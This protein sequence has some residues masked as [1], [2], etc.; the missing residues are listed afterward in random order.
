M[1]WRNTGKLAIAV[2]V[3]AGVDV[4]AHRPAPRPKSLPSLPAVDAT[5]VRG[6]RV[7]EG[8]TIVEFSRSGDLWRVTAPYQAR[9]DQ[10][11]VQGIVE[12]LARGVPMDV[13]VDALT[14]ENDDTYGLDNANLL[15]VDLLGEQGP[16]T[17]VYLGNDGPG[18]ASFVRRVDD[19]DVYRARLGG[20]HRYDRAAADWRDRQLVHVVAADVTSVVL[21]NVTLD[22]TGEGWRT[23]SGRADPDR[24]EDLVRGL[25]S[26]RIGEVLSTTPSGDPTATVSLVTSAGTSSIRFWR[27]V[28]GVVAAA[29]DGEAGRVDAA[30]LDVVSGAADAWRDQRLFPYRPD[31]VDAIV[32]YSGNRVTSAFVREKGAFVR[33]A[34]ENV[35][36][37]ARALT[38]ALTRL[39]QWRSE[40]PAPLAE[41]FR[42]ELSVGAEVHVLHL[43]AAAVAVDDGPARALPE[44]EVQRVLAG[45]R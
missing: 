33:T 12:R 21:P 9:A 23:E 20:R 40:A 13:R 17:T 7:Q 43:G 35:A 37:D 2:V 42:V 4:V 30:A 3:A 36:V 1:S 14:E 31:A 22:R 5:A 34:P 10:D 39:G 28:S 24:V 6:V 32:A 8:D 25:G 11:G 29:D 38:L 45:L 44:A 41:A 18:G 15:R 26:L 19:D 16:L 27:D